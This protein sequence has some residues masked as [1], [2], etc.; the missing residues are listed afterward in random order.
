V[1]FN[2]VFV[3]PGVLAQLQ[4]LFIERRDIYETREKKSKMYHWAP[5][6]TGLIVSELP[7]LVICA[8]LYYVC[9]YYTAGLPGDSNKAGA[10]FFIMLLY[11]FL[12]T[13]I[14]QFIAAYA[15][16]AVFASLVN[17]LLLGSLISFCGVLVPY[18]QIQ[19]F[20]RYWIYYLNP[21]TYLMGGLLV[22]PLFDKEVHCKESEFAVFD[23][24]SN[25]TCREYLAEYMQGQGLGSNLVNPDATSGCRVCKYTR[26]SDYLA[27]VNLK[28]YYYGW[29]DIGILAIFVFSSYA[30]VYGLMKLRT[31]ATKRAGD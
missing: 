25:Q 15:P 8:V 13:G 16:N 6:V 18:S 1:Q 27:T 21:F 14:G 11:E 4:P 24:P 19:E 31:K 12:Y 23:T 22:F 26:G 29:R 30:L 3:A 20:W 9:Y 7:Y 28:D 17:P 2:F 10:N 5:F